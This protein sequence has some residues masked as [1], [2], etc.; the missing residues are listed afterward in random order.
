[1]MD[2]VAVGETLK[3]MLTQGRQDERLLNLIVMRTIT[4]L[5]TKTPSNAAFVAEVHKWQ[6]ERVAARQ[7]RDLATELWNSAEEAD[8][9]FLRRRMKR[10]F[11][12]E[13]PLYWWESKQTLFRRDEEHPFRYR[14][15]EKF[16][17]EDAVI[18]DDRKTVYLDALIYNPDRGRF[19]LEEDREMTAWCNE[20]VDQPL[21]MDNILPSNLCCRAIPFSKQQ[22]EKLKS[23]GLHK[24]WSI[25]G[26]A[27][28]TKFKVD[29]HRGQHR[30]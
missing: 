17:D 18:A 16:E 11:I 27:D 29:V 8:L 3:A 28:I 22:A 23:F 15:D 1:M 30:H 4:G 5:D 26:V 7:S 19:R 20:N 25:P 24:E 14:I 12:Y 2:T 21:A 10:S 6:Q 13:Y 9:R